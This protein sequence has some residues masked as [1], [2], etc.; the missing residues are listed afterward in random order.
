MTLLS[1]VA[2]TMVITAIVKTEPGRARER[3]TCLLSAFVISAI[4]YAS[5]L[6]SG[7]VERV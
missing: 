3:I 6:Y 2:R 4:R 1:T 7:V 5:N